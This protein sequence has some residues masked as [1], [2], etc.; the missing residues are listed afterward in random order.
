MSLDIGVLGLVLLCSEEHWL[1]VMK[2][3]SH[4]LILSNVT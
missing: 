1:E 2:I 4:P 3:P